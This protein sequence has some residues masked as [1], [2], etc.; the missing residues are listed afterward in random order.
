[1]QIRRPRPCPRKIGKVRRLTWCVAPVIRGPTG[2]AGRRWSII[3]GCFRSGRTALALSGARANLA[4]IAAGQRSGAV[5]RS[6]RPAY[7]LCR[8]GPAGPEAR[9]RSPRSSKRELAERP[10][11]P[12]VL[13]NLGSIAV[14]RQRVARGAWLPPAQPGRVGTDRLDRAETVRPDRPLPPDAAG[15]LPAA[16]RRLRRGAGARPG[17]RRAAGS[18]RRMV[19]RQRGESSEAERAGGGS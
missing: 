4:G 12:F 10:D 1:M 7:R 8:P 3:S 2:M 5:D 6:D 17:R 9:P 19:H 15:I 13:F 14:E 16:L 11:D 18:A